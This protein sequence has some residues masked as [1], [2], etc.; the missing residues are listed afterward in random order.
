MLRRT[1]SLRALAP[2]VSV[3]LL[4]A[5]CAGTQ[6]LGQTSGTEVPPE[7]LGPSAAAQAAVTRGA[8]PLAA[9]AKPARPSADKREISDEARK[10]FEKAIESWEKARREGTFMSQCGSIASDFKEVADDYPVLIEAKGNEAAVLWEC[11]KEQ[12]A[13]RLF[14]QLA[15]G[16]KP[17]A[18][19]LAQLGYVAWRS[20][21]QS[22]AETLFQRAVDADKLIGSVSARLNL[23]QILRD[24]AKRT[25]NVGDKRQYNDQVLDHLRSVLAV[26]AN[27]LQAY[28]ALCHFYYEA[29]LWEMARLVGTQ[30]IGR[31]EEIATGKLIGVKADTAEDERKAQ[32]KKKGK[33][34]KAD[35]GDDAPAA[36]TITTKGTGYTPDMKKSL[37]QV[38]NTLGLMWLR[39]K[40]VSQAIAHFKKAVDMD[41]KLIESRMNLGA[42]SLNYRDYPTAETNFRA[43]L[44]SQK[45]NYEAA[46]GLGV[47]LRGNRKFDEAEQQY[48]TAQKVNPQAADTY[49]NLGLLY[50]EYK[51]FEKTTLLKAQQY[52][53]DYLGKNGAPGKRREAEKR[54]K[55]IDDTLAALEEAAKLQKEAEEMQRRDLEQQKK[56]EEELKKMQEQEKATQPPPAAATAPAGPQ[57]TTAAP[58]GAAGS[59]AAK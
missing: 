8:D 7:D 9:G 49:F 17:Y 6:K 1:S 27:N 28:V 22:R 19:A 32:G 42:L 21:D 40:D 48:L 12:E 29:E 39:R 4:G 2:L 41:P 47:A 50:Q 30:A 23:A 43:V 11:G 55:D 52:Y 59:A 18:P 56:N 20:G 51:G 44:E 25:S 53:R 10:D 24:K 57:A 15:G 5:G 3:C 13:M 37:G 38:H 45:D 54:I 46:L 26:D 36:R 14:E 16:A 35:K 33:G 58:G 31:A 34:E